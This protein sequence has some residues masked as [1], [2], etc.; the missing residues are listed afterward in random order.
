MAKR[1]FMYVPRYEIENMV[2]GLARLGIPSYADYMRSGLW[3]LTRRRL[4]QDSC[5]LCG[6]RSSL[7]LHHMTYVRLGAERLEDVCTL[8]SACHGE[9]HSAARISESLYPPQILKAR[10]GRAPQPREIGA[11]KLGCPMCS[12]RPGEP[13][14]RP[15]GIVRPQEHKDRRRLADAS[16]R[17]QGRRRRRRASKKDAR[18]TGLTVKQVADIK[19]AREAEF[20]LDSL[21]ERT[22]LGR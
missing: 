7:V 1:R 4:T 20:P 10:G 19:A 5:E 8:C 6:K 16:A 21:R 15:D 2:S 11:L 9:V 3:V 14:R 18:S 17:D 22:R 13:C 12:A